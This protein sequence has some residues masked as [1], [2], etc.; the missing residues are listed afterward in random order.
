MGLENRRPEELTVLRVLRQTRDKIMLLKS[1]NR[2][3]FKNTDYVLIYL[4]ETREKY[5][6]ER[7][8][9]IGHVEGGYSKKE[10]YEKSRKEYFENLTDKE[11]SEFLQNEANR[12]KCEYQELEN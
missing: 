4:M 12:I 5:L 2:K 11:K 9:V 10:L 6:K 3:M 1:A 7:K 8:N